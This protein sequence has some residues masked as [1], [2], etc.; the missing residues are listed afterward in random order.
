MV[1]GNDLNV[2]LKLLDNTGAIERKIRKALAKDLNQKFKDFMRTIS[3]LF[4]I[5]EEKE[6]SDGPLGGKRPF[7]L[8]KKA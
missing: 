4:L 7:Y 1:M 6:V 5:E 2:T 3:D 8:L